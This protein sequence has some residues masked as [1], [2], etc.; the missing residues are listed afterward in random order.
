LVLKQEILNAESLLPL[1]LGAVALP[2]FLSFLAC[3]FRGKPARVVML[4]ASRPAGAD[5]RKMIRRELRPYGHIIALQEGARGIDND[6]RLGACARLIRNKLA[7]NLRAFFARNVTLPVR[8]TTEWRPTTT[9]LLA[10]S[11]DA[12][13]VDLSNG[14]PQHWEIFQPLASR[15]V[16]VSA[17]GQQDQAEAAFASLG[18][19]GQCFFYAPDGEI[20]RRGQFRAAMLA[21]MRAA[22]A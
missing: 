9:Q 6:G 5:I 13:I 14:A 11:S 10:R 4:N 15:C 2:F 19:P 12:L 18:L 17:W 1:L 8:A 21:A 3:V 16:F 20:Q 7:M 22:H